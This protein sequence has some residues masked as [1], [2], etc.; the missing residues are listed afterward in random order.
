MSHP[1]LF[2]GAIMASAALMALL[3]GL[4]TWRWRAAPG[5]FYFTLLMIAVS[6]FA[7]TN[8][9]EFSVTSIPAKVTWSKLSYLG[10]V[11][12]SPLWLLFAASY[13]RYSSWLSPRRVA[14]LWILPVVILGLAMTNEW[15]RLIW[16]T[17]TPVSPEPGARLIYGHGIAFWTH[18]AYSYIL[19]LIGTILLARTTWRSQRLFRLQVSALLIA[20]I[21]PWLA[22][23]L[24]LMKL[25]PWPGMDLTPLGFVLTG[26]VVAWSL[27]RFHMLDLAPVAREILFD[28]LGD[29]V[30][31]LDNQDRVI[32]LN[33]TAHR[34]LGVGDEVLGQHINDV[35]GLGKIATQYENV[36][37]NHSQLEF[38]EG[39]ERQV[40]DLTISPLRDAR[41]ILQ[42]RVVLAHDISKEHDLLEA[43]RLNSQ[44][45]ETLNAI[46]RVALSMP[47]LQ[48]MLLALADR[49][50]ELL[51]A[52]GAYLTL[53]NEKQ[54]C[55]IPAAAYGDM[56][57]EYPTLK[58]EPGER[59]LTE[60]VLEAGH[61]LAIEDA[62]D[63]PHMSR[64]IAA[65]FP[66]RSMLAL[67]L[68]VD[69]HKLGAAIIAFNQTHHFTAD[70]IALGEVAARQIALALVKV[71]LYE[72]ERN[73]VVQLD[74]LHS[75]SQAVV[76]S[77]E[78]NQIFETVVQVLQGTFGYP[79]VSI[80][81]LDGDTLRL[82]AQVGFQEGSIY[83]E[84]PIDRGV[85]GRAVRTH[86]PQFVR[87]V[88]ND[89]DFLRIEAEI[90][91]EICVPLIKEDTVLGILNVES[92]SR[93]SLREADMELLSAFANQVAVAIENANLFQAE[94]DQRELAEGLREVG[95]AMGRS[96]DF[97]IVLDRLLDWIGR[98]VPFDS[99][100]ILLADENSR[101]ARV[102][103][104]AGYDKF[105]E[106]V[107]RQAGLVTLDI[108]ATTNLRHM[109]ETG[110]PL[111]VSNTDEYPG[112]L[113]DKTAAHVQSWVGAPIFT[114]G[115]L[116]GFFSLDKFEPGYYR[117]E[118]AERLS[119][120]AGQAA[121]A[122]ENARLFSET[123]R[124]AERE[125]LLFAATRDFT[126]RLGEEA[127]LMAVAMHMTNAMGVEECAISR[128]DPSDACVVTLLDYS[129]LAEFDCDI[130]ETVY[131]LA[132]FPAT[133]AVIENR[134]PLLLHIDEPS[135]DRAEYDLLIEYGYDA[136]LII[137]LVAGQEAK[138]YGIAELYGSTGIHPL[139][140]S[141]LEMVQSLA[142]QAAAALDNARLY[143]EVQRLAIV[144]EL[145]S[146]YNRR[147]FFELGKRE[148]ER[149]TRFKRL[150]AALFVDID[151]FKLIN[152]SYSYSI[153]D[154]VLRELA[155]CLRENLRE[156]DLPG[157]YGGEEFIALLPE[158]DLPAA[159]N[160]AE[161]VR[162][163]VESMRVKTDLGEVS[164][165]VSIGV[166]QK[167]PEMPDL[168]AL[169]HRAGETLH[170]AKK[171]GRNRIAVS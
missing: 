166:C 62:F 117:L 157:R 30:I 6:V 37:E 29:G 27:F 107:S 141:D 93:H 42:G 112:W 145:T 125:R 127:V 119:A 78:L 140:E 44:Q 155:G 54:G 81:R 115:K 89:P 135:I 19:M 35:A 9:A 49:L 110:G 73:R 153:G 147:G 59:T 57:D 24:Y 47:D 109:V 2:P 51:N 165:T 31:V 80:Y 61:A 120:F 65:M 142:A 72:A 84:I 151:H 86:S 101:Q 90:E 134:Q 100:C 32:D 82:G 118:H 111:V 7:F 14:A 4:Y 16:P 139:S 92:P 85:T 124:R 156:T 67:P 53:W 18:A 146:V 48:H 128:W 131:P 17:I 167:T 46:T 132:D 76:S 168:E 56:R 64:R 63:T 108:P 116:A 58:P 149:A 129:T 154:Q 33:P 162:R 98:V 121:I 21:I 22:N 160:V 87:D 28:N 50:G 123:R 25:N 102:A 164:I 13:G 88:E 79:Y 20:A 171:G 143:A 34:W 12:V 1:Y 10:I 97:E 161:R 114:K 75:I 96:L 136:V 74:G 150:L 66:T 41:G 71:R 23:L 170:E 144:D 152:D 95:M 137:P 104:M 99:A 122:I 103:R 45:M 5:G 106:E 83:R 60:S 133:R 70:E 138:V 130:P 163:S 3:I 36:E 105:G 15:H 126:A 77:L 8:A 91:S 113:K 52:D 158:T 40:F 39:D 69:E 11:S 43:E 159:R 68:I 169:I 26:L 148:W 94:R 38:S 55:T